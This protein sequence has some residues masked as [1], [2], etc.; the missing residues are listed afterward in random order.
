[1]RLT[2]CECNMIGS[3][4]TSHLTVSRQGGVLRDPLYVQYLEQL[5]V[6]NLIIIIFI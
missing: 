4:M 2:S 6:S 5:P 1:M 3:N